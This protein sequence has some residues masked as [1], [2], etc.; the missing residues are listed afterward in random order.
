MKMIARV[1]AAAGV[2]VSLASYASAKTFTVMPG[3]GT[4]LQDAIDAAAPNDTLRL[5]AGTYPEAIVVN[6]AL[7]IFGNRSTINAGCGALAAVTIAADDVSIDRITAWGG[8]LYE[9]DIQNRDHVTLNIVLTSPSCP[10]VARGINAI[11]TTRLLVKNGSYTTY[12]IDMN[13]AGNC[14]PFPNSRDFG[15]AAIFVGATPAGGKGRLLTNH[16][17]GVGTAILLEDTIATAGGQPTV[18]VRKSDLFENG[19]GIVLHNSDDAAI[20]S[21]VVSNVLGGSTVGIEVDAGSDDNVLAQN[22]VDGYP[23]DVSDA[24]SSNCWRSNTFT[25]GSVPATGCP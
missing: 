22:K 11:N 24:G 19:R 23:T 8:T 4:P 17:C 16:A 20:R 3:P 15:E 10:G 18:T 9:V 13:H 7:K 1:V 6:K 14:P 5:T 12:D 25:T 21:N 2:G